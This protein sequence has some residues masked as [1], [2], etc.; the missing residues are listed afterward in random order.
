MQRL[1]P[2]DASYAPAMDLQ[3]SD[4]PTAERVRTERGNPSV[5]EVDLFLPLEAPRPHRSG[6]SG[7][8]RATLS[9]RQ[10]ALAGVAVA[11]LAWGSLHAERAVRRSQEEAAAAA[12]ELRQREKERVLAEESAEKMRRRL[13]AAAAEQQAEQ[14]RVTAAKAELEAMAQRKAAEAAE[15]AN[16]SAGWEQFYKP[17]PS[18]RTS[19]T[20]DCANAYIRAKRRFEEQAR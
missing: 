10:V 2:P 7:Q 18:C 4:V 17:N 1:E 20:V 12:A 6:P 14:A 16:R 19:W 15:A 5:P 11:V 8:A 9:W 3:S 13:E